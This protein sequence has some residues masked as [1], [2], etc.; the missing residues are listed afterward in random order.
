MLTKVTEDRFKNRQLTVEEQEVFQNLIKALES[1]DAP[2]AYRLPPLKEFLASPSATVLIPKT[3]VLAAKKAAEPLYVASQFFKEVKMKQSGALYI[4]PT[5]GPMRAFDIAEGQEFPTQTID[6]EFFEGVEI[7]IGKSGVRLQFTEE[8]VSEAQWDII[9]MMIEEAGKA[10]A[11]HKEQ[12]IFRHFTMHGWPVFDN[13][14]RSLYPEAGTT[15]IAAD[16]TFNDTFSA[17]DF[18]DLIIA[19]YM[20]EFT[21]DTILMHPL[22]WTV[23]AKQE[24]L[25][26]VMAGFNI[27]PATGQPTSIA[28]GPQSIQGRIPFA[29]NVMLSPM[30]PLNL[31]T[32]RY[33]MYAIDSNNIGVILKKEGL[34][35]DKFND[36]TRDIYNIKLKEKYGIGIFHEGRSIAVA[37]NISM[38]PSFLPPR[39]VRVVG[40]VNTS[41]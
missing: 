13:V 29:F 28:L 26:Q 10:M 2:E 27:Y 34:S 37:R 25:G 21:P 8:M 33:D 35:T 36:P 11:R 38:A 24:L 3:I 12:K 40:N 7:R 22:T 32:K 4:F 20:N 39:T 1:T 17:E 16:G 23:F 30:I 6:G 18:L 5:F 9:A 31:Q 15:G 19:V 41:N 14:K